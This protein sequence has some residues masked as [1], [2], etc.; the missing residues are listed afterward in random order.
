MYENITVED[1]KARFKDG[2][3]THVLLDV[4]TTEEFEQ[5]RIPGAINIPLDELEARVDEVT[6]TANDTP[7]VLVCR[8]GVRSIMGAK[9]LYT[10][11][12][13]SLDLYN[14]DTGTLGW[15]QQGL[16]LDR[17]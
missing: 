13:K 5:A 4:R 10:A 6:E 12:V 11:G 2:E 7:V 3:E 9:A 14:I 1:Y 17:G 8:S 15:A 16:P